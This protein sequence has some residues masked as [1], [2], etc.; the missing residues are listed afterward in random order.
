MLWK[1]HLHALHVYFCIFYTCT[2]ANIDREL[3]HGKAIFYQHFPKVHIGF[4]LLLGFCRQIKE[5]ENPHNA[6]LT[7][8][9]KVDHKRGYSSG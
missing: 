5:Y 9:F 6:I 3:E 8:A 7:E 1:A 2:V 4:L